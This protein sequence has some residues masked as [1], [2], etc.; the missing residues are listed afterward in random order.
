ME[1]Y[2]AKMKGKGTPGRGNSRVARTVHGY[3]EVQHP[4]AHTHCLV[5]VLQQH[6]EMGESG[7]QKGVVLFQS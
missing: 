3:R 6:T 1:D 2:Q 4:R 7:G 5:L